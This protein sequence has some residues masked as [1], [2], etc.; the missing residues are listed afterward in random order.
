MREGSMRLHFLAANFFRWYIW[1]VDK[2]VVVM[3]NEETVG[4]EDVI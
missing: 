3:L 4:K 1:F 2:I